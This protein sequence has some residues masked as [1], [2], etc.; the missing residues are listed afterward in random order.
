MDY[1]K[2]KE[3]FLD[4]FSGVLGTSKN[5]VSFDRGLRTIVFL[6]GI[7][8]GIDIELKE[9]GILISTSYFCELD[10]INIDQILMLIGSLKA[11]SAHIDYRI[12]SKNTIINQIMF[13]YNDFYKRP[14]VSLLVGARQFLMYRQAYKLAK[15][16]S[17]VWIYRREGK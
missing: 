4:V 8:M 10:G 15:N 11:N 12:V 16:G 6:N 1:S 14:L 17:Y 3:Y 13:R 9:M 2:T 7:R 5:F